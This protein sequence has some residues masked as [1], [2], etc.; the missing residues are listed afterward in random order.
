MKEIFEFLERRISF[1]RG[2]DDEEEET[3]FEDGET[4]YE[5]GVEDGR[6]KEAVFINKKIKELIK[7]QS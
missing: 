4:I 5:K 7:N 6:F 1:L 3:E 2:F